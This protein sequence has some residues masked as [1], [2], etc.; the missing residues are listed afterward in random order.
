MPA[1]G[2][3]EAVHD[4]LK[5]EFEDFTEITGYK[6]L[7]NGVEVHPE[8]RICVINGKSGKFQSNAHLKRIIENKK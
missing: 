2:K 5:R 6:F 4:F 8:S 1:G 7:V 3:K